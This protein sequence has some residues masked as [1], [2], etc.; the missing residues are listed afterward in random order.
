VKA[1]RFV[2]HGRRAARLHDA[3]SDGSPPRYNVCHVREFDV[4]RG[5][6]SL[7]V[8]DAGDP[9]GTPIVYFHATPG[10]RIDMAFADDIAGE[11]GVRIV[12]FDRPG[13]GGSTPAAFGLVS[14]ASD[15]GAIADELGIERFATLGQSGGGPFSLAAAATLGDRVTRA[16]VASGAGPFGLVPGSLG[17]LDETDTAAVSLLPGDPI[18]AQRGF[19]SGFEPL[20]SAF[21]GATS[22]DIVAA[23]HDSLSRRDNELMQ[24]E[25]LM[26]ALGNSMRESLRQGPDGGGW[27]NVAWVGTWEIDVTTIR[28]P[29]LLWYG[30]EDRFCPPAH[31]EWLRDNIAGAELT[32]RPGEGHFGFIEHTAEILTALTG[33]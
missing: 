11:L 9:Y 14:V 12:S 13:Y 31:G 7:R 20:V 22:A 18:G 26:T 5:D 6:R 23:F 21:R 15:A 16:G 32:M 29:V 8:R 30:D 1:G 4:V 2:D 19:A 33:T 17:Q 27:D 25:H 24:D 3:D 10:S 28:C